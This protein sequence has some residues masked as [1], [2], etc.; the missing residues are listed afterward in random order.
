MFTQFFVRESDGDYHTTHHVSHLRAL[1]RKE[2][3]SVLQ[4][5]G[6][7]DIH[8]HMPAESEFYQPIVTARRR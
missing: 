3:S 4:D 1:R 2:L 6:F 8:W 7:S 5:T